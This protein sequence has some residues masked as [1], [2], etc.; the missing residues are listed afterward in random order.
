[1]DV[2]GGHSGDIASA[3][4]TYMKTP[5]GKRMPQ[6]AMSEIIFASSEEKASHRVAFF[7][8]DKT[9]FQKMYS[10]EMQQKADFQLMTTTLDAYSANVG[11]YY[12][13]SLYYTQGESDNY[14]VVLE[15]SVSDPAAYLAAFKPFA[16]AIHAKWGGK[17]GIALHQFLSG[18]EPGVSHV[19][20]INTPDFATYMTVFDEVNISDF[21]KTF[22]NKVKDMRKL[23]SNSSSVTFA[24]YNT[25]E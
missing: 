20:V 7:S 4:D 9:L 15:L 16:D 17:V 14:E 22:Y 24:R 8:P 23:V 2:Q 6:M 10:G 5:D 13:K 25:P 18:Q 19:V 12:G 11:A 21:Y 1:M 3:I